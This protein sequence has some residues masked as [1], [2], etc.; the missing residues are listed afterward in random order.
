MTTLQTFLAAWA[1]V[2][3]AAVTFIRGATSRPS[4]REE[5][6]IDQLEFEQ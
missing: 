3:V 4:S 5:R 6:R 2:A 1:L